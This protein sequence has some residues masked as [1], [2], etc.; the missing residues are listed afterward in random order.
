MKTILIAGDSWGVGVFDG[1]TSDDTY[2]PIGQGLHTV[3]KEHNYNI[4]NISK[5]GGSNWLMVDRL[6]SQWYNWNR[7]LYGIDRRDHVRFSWDD[8]DAIVYF[9]TDLFRE[10][11]I[12]I[13]E[14]LTDKFTTVKQLD[15]K[16]IDSL[17][18]FDSINH[19]IEDYFQKFYTALNAIG[20]KRNKKIY[21]IGGWNQLHPSI[22][23]YSNLI[24]V[25]ASATKFLIPEVK[26]DSYLSDPEWYVQLDTDP[27]IMKKF[28]SELKPMAIANAEKLVLV[29]EQWNDCHPKLDGFRKIAEQL[30]PLLG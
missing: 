1:N 5:A 19:F 20:Q 17:L 3:L 8:V 4:I 24:P 28:G 18:N 22:A 2:G 15:S 23:N 10:R 21:C 9:Q 13:K 7:C 25:L 29:Y 11:Y 26:E 27:R 16:L 30:I 6:N 12:Y 14:N